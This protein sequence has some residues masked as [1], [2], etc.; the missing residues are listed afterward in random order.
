VPC[1]VREEVPSEPGCVSLF[2]ALI[3][4]LLTLLHLR[5]NRQVIETN[6]SNER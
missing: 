3:A 5:L 1:M 6:S 4:C 2:H